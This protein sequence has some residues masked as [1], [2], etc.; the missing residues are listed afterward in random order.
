MASLEFIVTRNK[1]TLLLY[2]EQFDITSIYSLTIEEQQADITSIASFYKEQDDITS[3]ATSTRN[4]LTLPLLPASTLSC[5]LITE[6][7]S[8]QFLAQL[9]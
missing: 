1:L 2:K 8:F 9:Q 7:H 5:S 6:E 3:I 4:K